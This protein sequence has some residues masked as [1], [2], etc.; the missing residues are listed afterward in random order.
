MTST[1]PA[2]SSLRE[3]VFSDSPSRRAGLSMIRTFTPRRLAA[4]T[5]FKSD[6]SEKMNILTR[7][8]FVAPLM[9]S[10]IG[11]AESSGSTIKEREDM[12]SPFDNRRLSDQSLPKH[13]P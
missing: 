5:A 1:P 7:R 2:S 9:A 8:D 11:F 6:G 13:Q 12:G 10:R 3:S 4:I